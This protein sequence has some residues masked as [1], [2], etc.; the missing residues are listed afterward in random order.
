MN[1][2][3][4]NLKIHLLLV[5]ATLF[6]GVTPAFMKISLQEIDVFI[7][8]TLRLFIALL[9]SGL[10]LIISGTWKKVEKRD[11]IQF[12]IIGLFGFFIFQFCFPIGVK[13]SSASISALIM[14][15]LPVNVILINLLSRTES[16]TLRTVIGISFSI[17]GIVVIIMGTSGGISLEGTYIGG[18]LL[19]IVAEM[20]FAVYTVKSKSLIT[21]YSL[22]QVMFIVILFSFVPFLFLS[23]NQLFSFSASG[24]SSIAWT[25]VFF[26]GIFGTC[27]GNILWYQGV[28]KMGSVK[29]SIYANLPP[30][31]GVIVSFI[32]LG[33]TLALVQILGGFVIIAGVILVSRKNT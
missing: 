2:V 21:R 22:Y 11:W 15:S 1:R 10:L 18:V 31:F 16:I 6:W 28:R 14:A 20:G 12:V 17:A 19:L 8:S 23:A 29:T 30:V 25:G 9:T 7:F 13:H 33:E 32:F 27:I 5:L 24:V 4:S 3:S 26:T